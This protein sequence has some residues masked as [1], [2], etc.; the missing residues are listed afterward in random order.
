[1]LVG[2]GTDKGTPGILRG[3]ERKLNDLTLVV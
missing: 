3:M 1:V 2:V